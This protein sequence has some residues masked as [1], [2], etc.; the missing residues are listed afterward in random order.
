[1]MLPFPSLI[2]VVLLSY[3]HSVTFSVFFSPLVPLY[4][5]YLAVISVCDRHA[6]LILIGSGSVA[7]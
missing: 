6:L 1:M 2:S 5:F 7:E 4:P 3:S